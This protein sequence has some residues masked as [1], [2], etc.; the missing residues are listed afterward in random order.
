MQKIHDAAFVE[1]CLKRIRYESAMS[2]LRSRLFAVQYQKGEFVTSPLQEEHLFQIVVQGSLNVYFIRDDGSVHSLSNGQEN[3]LLGEME[4]F[5]SQT[6]NVYAEASADLVCL[7]LSIEENKKELLENC[8][9]LQM[10]CQ[11]L[12]EKMQTITTIDAAPADLKQRV[13]TYLQYKCG[14]R[15][16][17]GLQQTAF[18]LNCSVRQLQ[19]ILHQYE[20][21]GIV[22][23]T[24]QGAYQL[25]EPFTS[26]G[27]KSR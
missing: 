18:R 5:S 7:A 20:A 12:T 17:K 19:R 9:F 16:I 1:A 26:A 6:G 10:L 24:G 22:I 13:L 15:G 27:Q 21:A 25:R 2:G 11:S 14:S 8:R 3:Y 23:K 4:I